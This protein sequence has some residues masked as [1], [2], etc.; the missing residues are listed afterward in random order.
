MEILYYF[1]L[2]FTIGPNNK[3]SVVLEDMTDTQ[4][5]G[6]EQSPGTDPCLY[7]QLTF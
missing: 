7:G 4:I 5:N 2:R 1:I 6:T 3:A